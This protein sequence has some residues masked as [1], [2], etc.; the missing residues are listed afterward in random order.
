MKKLL[1]CCFAAL[2]ITLFA[3]TAGAQ[4]Q[5][6][7]AVVIGNQD[8]TKF[9]KLTKTRTDA[10][11]METALHSIGFTV[12]KVPDGNLQQMQAALTWLRNRL[13]ESEDAIGFF[14]YSGHGA[15]D[16]SGG[17]YLI[18]V[19]A[20]IPSESYVGMRALALQTVHEEMSSAGN[21]LN[22]IVL[23]AC[24]DFPAAWSK[25]MSKG[26]GRINYRLV[27]SLIVYATTPGEVA[28]EDSTGKNSLYTEHLLKYLASPDL[29][30]NEMFRRVN[31]DVVRASRERQIPQVNGQYF[32]VAVLNPAG[33]RPPP[34]P[35]PT[36]IVTAPPVPRNVRAGT[37]GT[38]RVAISW[39]SAGSGLRYQVYYNTQN[40][41]SRA[42]VVGNPTTETSMNVIGMA[43][44]T[45]YYFWVASVQ[46]G[47]ESEKSSV[48]SIKT[49]S[50]PVNPQPNPNPAVSLYDQLVNATG[51][52][53]ITV[54]QNTA[55]PEHVILS[56][57]ASITLRGDTASRTVSWTRLGGRITIEKG[58]TFTLENITLRDIY[59]WVEAGGTLVM[60][61]AAT[62]TGSSLRV[63]QV[64][65]TFTMNGGSIT[66]NGGGVFVRD[67]GIFIMN[68]G[69]ISYNNSN[70]GSTDTTGGGV[71]IGPGG[72]FTMKAG[73]IEN[74]TARNGGG[75]C[76]MGTFYMQ[77]G[78]IASNSAHGD[79]GGVHAYIHSV[80]RMTGGTIYGSNGGS[81]ANTATGDG[82]AVYDG[83]VY[84]S[85]KN[86]TISQYGK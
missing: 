37:P 51:T 14:Y 29:H 23:D 42:D 12:N 48:V 78:T 35:P 84:S 5:K 73:R 57:A 41:P 46:N 56:K 54:T 18:P 13:G 69:S 6:K 8:Y 86:R 36:P 43:G 11:D 24:R 67:N 26:L 66:N 2:G 59:I 17:N 16:R 63:V 47:K 81:N 75:V 74:N 27:N 83:N 32:G 21:Q 45:Y 82:N 28:V 49:A 58:V 7:Y 33:V 62:I 68:G 40:D 39:D 3:A 60:N 61:N 70:T 64:Q 50:I 19:D 4:N 31:E 71:M 38:D 55:L 85:A 25:S 53:T 22:I 34:N 76:S 79:G 65:G 9:G 10:N 20:D 72:S 44:E 15:Q 1:V 77:G 30:V 52:V 80:F